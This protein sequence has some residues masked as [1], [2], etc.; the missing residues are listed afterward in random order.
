MNPLWIYLAIVIWFVFGTLISWQ[1]RKR[2][3]K[4]V[5]EYFLANRRIGGVIGAFRDCFPGSFIDIAG[6]ICTEILDSRE[7][8][9]LCYPIRIIG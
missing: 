5:T 1:A 8:I 3:G 6:T 2:L 7:E 4:G 9:R